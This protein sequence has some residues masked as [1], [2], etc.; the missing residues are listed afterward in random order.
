M[1]HRALIKQELKTEH[2]TSN[3]IVLCN[4][5][6]WIQ[7][8][9]KMHQYFIQQNNSCKKKSSYRQKLK[10]SWLSVYQLCH[11]NPHS[12]QYSCKPC[13]SLQE[14]LKHFST[15]FESK[16]NCQVVGPVIFFSI[17]HPETAKYQGH[18]SLHV[19]KFS[20]IP[21][22]GAAITQDDYSC[23]TPC[24]CTEFLAQLGFL[25]Q[26]LFVKLLHFTCF[27]LNAFN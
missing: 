22:F 14:Q 9:N 5:T 3:F 20:S 21:L 25:C 11:S 2:F 16:I 13:P 23:L 24:L 1:L 7:E 10:L 19:N 18:S 4:Y 8:N 15:R 17:S 27:P 26:I 12:R 6:D